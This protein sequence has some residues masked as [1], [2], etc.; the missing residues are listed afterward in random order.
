MILPATGGALRGTG[1]AALCFSYSFCT[2]SRSAA[3]GR[4]QRTQ[5]AGWAL[6]QGKQLLLWHSCL[7][8]S[9]LI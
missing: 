8:I 2:A 4:S 7:P 9:A 5:W 6:A 1:G 3:E